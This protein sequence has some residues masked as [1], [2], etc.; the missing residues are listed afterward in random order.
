MCAANRKG[1]DHPGTADHLRG[2][3]KAYTITV[4][5]IPATQRQSRGVPLVIFAAGSVPS[6]AEVVVTQSC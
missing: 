4:N 3:G 1:S 6:D 2:D 5:D